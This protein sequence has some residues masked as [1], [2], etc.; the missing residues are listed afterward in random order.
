MFGYAIIVKPPP[1]PLC[2]QQRNRSK[3]SWTNAVSSPILSD[4]TNHTDDRIVRIL[5]ILSEQRMQGLETKVS[6]I[7]TN[8]SEF[9]IELGI[10]DERSKRNEQNTNENSVKLVHLA[11]CI[12]ITYQE[13]A[14]LKDKNCAQKTG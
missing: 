1:K 14:K 8:L 6:N 3:L 11:N 13:L 10:I 7:E 2:Q 5:E 4:L 9:K 12:N